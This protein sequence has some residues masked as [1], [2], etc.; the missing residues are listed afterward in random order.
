MGITDEELVRKEA[1]EA[2]MLFQT[3]LKK[4]S[5]VIGDEVNNMIEKN[6]L[7]VNEVIEVLKTTKGD[8]IMTGHSTNKRICEVSE[9]IIEFN[10]YHD[11]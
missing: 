9:K 11:K 3:S 7:D 1:K 8:V 4:Q 10:Y 5:P 2:L 6:Y